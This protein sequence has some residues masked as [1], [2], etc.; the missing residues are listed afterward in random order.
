MATDYNEETFA[1][2]F[3]VSR[4]TLERF[5]IYA[6]KLE[7]WNQAINLV[8]RDTLGDLWRRH[9]LDSAQL[10]HCLPRAVRP[11][12]CW[13]D[14]GSGAGF[15]GL[16]L[17]LMSAGEFHLVDSD[18]RKC[19]FLREVSRETGTPVHIHNQRIDSLSLPTADYVTARACA[20]LPRLVDYARPLLRPGGYCLFLKGARLDEELTLLRKAGKMPLDISGAEVFPS[21]SDS[22]GRILRLGPY[23]S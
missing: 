22:K 9:F 19:T 10:L 17:A 16:V 13:V 7:K 18:A 1:R 2:D 5:R 14:L 15:P 4:E 6:A 20:P 21:E 12:T 8:S 23:S 11:D 3:D